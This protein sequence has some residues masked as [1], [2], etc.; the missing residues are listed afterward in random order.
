[1]PITILH[2]PSL[3]AIVGS[4]TISPARFVKY[5]ALGS[6]T[7]NPT[8]G[9]LVVQ[10]IAGQQP[11]GISETG[12]PNAPTDENYGGG[13]AT[14]TGST[15]AKGTSGTGNAW[16][17]G[18]L[19]GIHSS[20]RNTLLELGSTI[21]AGAVLGPDAYGRGIPA[22]VDFAGAVAKQGGVTGDLIQVIVEVS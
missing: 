17:K 16:G 7:T 13:I 4:G 10:C 14:A 6:S 1:M 2:G 12:A 22:T 21:S 18:D 9:F 11:L 19:I 20:G 5:A 3:S 8:N 15:V